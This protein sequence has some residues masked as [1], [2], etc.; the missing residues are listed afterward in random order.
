VPPEPVAGPGL[1]GG[2]GHDE[3]RVVTQASHGRI[4]L[5]PSGVVQHAGVDHRA[6]RP[7]EVGAEDAL[8]RG[9][10]RRAFDTDLGERREVEQRDGSTGGAV[11]LGDGVEPAGA[12]EG[13]VILARSARRRVPQGTLPAGRFAEHGAGVGEAVAQR[14]A[15]QPAGGLGLAERPVHRVEAAEGFTGAL[16]EKAG[17]GLGRR[18]AT[19]VDPSRVHGRGAPVDPRREGASHA[20]AQDDAL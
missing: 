1:G 4:E 17:G 18:E 5:D 14:D 6:R 20:G 9:Q 12:S 3:E 10:R 13:V 11:L 16:E 19:H 8:H 15:P 2:R 7:V